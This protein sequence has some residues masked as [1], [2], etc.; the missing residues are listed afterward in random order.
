MYDIFSHRSLPAQQ[1]D[2]TLN[3][4]ACS[5]SPPSRAYGLS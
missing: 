2:S 3:G 4:L 5:K 1:R